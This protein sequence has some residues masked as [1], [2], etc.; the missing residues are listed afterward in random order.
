MDA[1]DKIAV[2]LEGVYVAKSSICKVDGINGK[3]YY[4][5]YAIE[6]IAKNSSFEEVCYLLLNGK[7]PKLAEFEEFKKALYAERD[8][9]EEIVGIISE[10]VGKASP[11][12]IL[13]TAFSALS[14][15]D[16]KL[17]DNTEQ[18]NMEKSLKIIS[19]IS[20]ISAAIGRLES[21]A[22]Y[23][24]PD[25]SLSHSQNFL[26]MLNGKKPEQEKADLLD[27]MMM[28]HAEHS[29]NASTF[30]TLVTGSTL[31]DIYAAV[32]S[33]ISTLKGPLHGGADEAAL[34]M[35]DAIGSPENTERYIDEALAGK[36]RIMG[37]GHR[38]YKTYDPRA[39]IIRGHLI[40][41]Q[42]HADGKV[43]NLTG[44]ALA[45]EKMMV[46]KLGETKGIWPNVDFFS[47]PI[48]A[49]LGVPGN[50][51]TPLFAASRAPGWCAHMIEYWRNNKLFRPLEYYE[52]E[53]DKQYLS[54]DKR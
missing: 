25:K 18:A 21:K 38:V 16:E 50:L 34:K 53:I 20:S 26:Y 1:D 15:F 3:L 4:R 19:R 2:G 52:G 30:S 23:V 41:I 51:F 10:L 45:A 14:G 9:P 49:Y 42:E 33:G 22:Q 54:I 46:E 35:M 11:M 12:D 29:S 5:G 6:D 13:R 40:E 8:L 7:L 31:A 24:K 44:I 28:L 36:Q 43:K 48:Y 37:F 27:L 17:N 39:K 47:G 32:T